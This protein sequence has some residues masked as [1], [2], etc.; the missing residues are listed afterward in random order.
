M[1]HEINIE[2]TNSDNESFVSLVEELDEYLSGINGDQDNFFRQFN[3]IEKVQ[4]VVV[5][6]IN[7]VAIGCGALKR[8]DDRTVEVKRMYVKPIHRGKNI[9]TLILKELEKWAR[10]EQFSSVVLETSKTMKPAVHLYKKNEYTVIPN[11][12]PYKEIASSICFKKVLSF[13]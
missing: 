5:C 9:A 3:T 8:I 6:Y 7:K 2:R 12:E 11:Y 10:E 1:H 4:N 13:F